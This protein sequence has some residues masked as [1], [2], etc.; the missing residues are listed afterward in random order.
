MPQLLRE[1][2]EEAEAEAAEAEA[3]AR[4]EELVDRPHQ[5]PP[6]PGPRRP[7]A[8]PATSAWLKAIILGNARQIVIRSPVR[9]VLLMGNMPRGAHIAPQ[10]T[11]PMRSL[12]LPRGAMCR[13]AGSD[14]QHRA[15][16]VIAL[17]RTSQPTGQALQPW[18]ELSGPPPWTPR[19]S[20]GS[21]R[22]PH[23]ASVPVI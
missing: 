15:I 13:P 10:P 8:L 17:V 2:E 4:E 3:E 11:P 16:P 23:S 18:P 14:L 9:N 1:D 5:W 22:G 6:Q 21:H 12:W 20:I 7:Q 19:R